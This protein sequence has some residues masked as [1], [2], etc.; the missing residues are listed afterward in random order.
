MRAHAHLQNQ[1]ISHWLQLASALK[2]VGSSRDHHEQE[3]GSGPGWIRTGKTRRK[4]G[5]FTSGGGAV[6][7]V[8]KC[9]G[10]HS[11]TG[12]RYFVTVRHTAANDRCSASSTTS[13][14]YCT[15]CSAPSLL[16]SMSRSAARRTARMIAR[17]LWRLQRHYSA[18]IHVRTATDTDHMHASGNL[19]RHG[20][21]TPIKELWIMRAKRIQFDPSL[22]KTRALVSATVRKCVQEIEQAMHSLTSCTTS[23]VALNRLPA[24]CC[25][26]N[27]ELILV[28][29]LGLA[30]VECMQTAASM[31]PKNFVGRWTEFVTAIFNE[32][33]GQSLL[34]D[35]CEAYLSL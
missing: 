9:P 13:T 28:S 22:A 32:T 2:S 30:G 4:G 15:S 17:A 35:T 7:Y 27:I 20:S 14:A 26:R 19:L 11:T 31:V 16:L 3:P 18:H 24:E 10:G 1:S 34:C 6:Y 5:Q 23:A 25:E 12:G 29:R 8:A 33:S 21:S